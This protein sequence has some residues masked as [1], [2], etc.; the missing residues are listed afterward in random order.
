[1]GDSTLRRYG[2]SR[3]MS[4]NRWFAGLVGNT[5][6]C[7]VTGFKLGAGWHALLT[8][9]RL[10]LPF[11]NDSAARFSPREPYE[12]RGSRTVLEE[13]RGENPR[14][15]LTSGWYRLST[16]GAVE[17]FSAAPFF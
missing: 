9:I 1:M 14:G 13:P 2:P 12:S 16:T 6:N 8:A 4:A 3:G 7:A 11:G 10:S 15:Y 5:R 17:S